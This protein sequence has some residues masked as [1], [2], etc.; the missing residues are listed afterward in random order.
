[1][2]VPRMRAVVVVADVACLP[3]CPRTTL[4]GEPCAPTDPQKVCEDRTE[5]RCDGQ[6]YVLNAACSAEC[7]G[8]GTVVAHEQESI[9][10]D[11]TWTCE[12]G[13]HVV[14]GTVNV[15]AGATLTIAPGAA[16]R[17]NSSSRVDVDRAGRLVVDAPAEA[18]VVVT[19]NN[20]ELGGYG[21]ATSGGINVFAAEGEPSIVRGL[22]VERGIHGIG[23]FGLSSTTNTPV[24]QRS[25]FRDNQNFG[26]KVTCDEIDFG[27]PDFAVS[28]A[29]VDNDAPC[30]NQFFSNGAGDVSGCE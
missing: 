18:P 5:L 29:D 12:D 17:I 6:V 26:I 8:D 14:T 28:C 11:D 7:D 1:M 4:L 16:V 19:A 3:A 2:R 15:G 24:V 23:I 9:D 13:I 25:T 30:G 10:A 21:A 27:V 20:G 22:I